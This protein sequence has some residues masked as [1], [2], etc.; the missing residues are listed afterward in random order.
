MKRRSIFVLAA[1]M[2]ASLL[3]VAPATADSDDAQLTVV[4]GIPE[5]TV[6]VYVNGDKTL[7]DFTPGTITDPLTLPSG[8]YTVDLYAPGTGPADMAHSSAPILTAMLNLAA[9]SN[10]SAIAHLDDAGEP[11]DQRLRQ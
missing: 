9:G 11:N 6:D 4:H 8:D 7:P 5:T 2:I 10:V 3:A 1:L